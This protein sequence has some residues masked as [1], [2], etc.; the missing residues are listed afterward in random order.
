MPDVPVFDD[1]QIY[2]EKKSGDMLFAD[3]HHK[4]VI[5]YL[6]GFHMEVVFIH[7]ERRYPKNKDWVLYTPYEAPVK[8][9]K[10]KV[11][12]KGSNKPKKKSVKNR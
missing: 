12:P 5:C 10:K 6:S 4:N 1:G 11:R 8:T 2:L 3:P 9:V 7:E